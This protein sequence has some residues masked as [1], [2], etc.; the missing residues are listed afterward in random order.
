MSN[1]ELK[2][3]K[4]NLFKMLE[5]CMN[6][7]DILHN[8]LDV[9]KQ[10]NQN[11]KKNVIDIAKENEKIKSEI[12][13]LKDYQLNHL[14]PGFED[15][16]DY[17]DMKNK[18]ENNKLENNK[19]KEELKTYKDLINFNNNNNKKYLEEI[20]Y[21]YYNYVNGNV[22]VNDNNN[23]NEEIDRTQYLINNNYDTIYYNKS[24]LIYNYY[25]LYRNYLK[26]KEF[27]IKAFIKNNY[28]YN[29]TFIEKIKISYKF[30]NDIL[31]IV[32]DIPSYL[33]N[34]KINTL[35]DILKKC[36]IT[37]N[38]LYNL[39]NGSY[40]DLIGFITPIII[41][42]CKRKYEIDKMIHNKNM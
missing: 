37:E 17:I 20:K 23:K 41:T 12:I 10:Q 32:K 9:L 38:K 21:N 2:M 39:E 42:E 18:M 15:T 19:L 24:K 11:Y 22:E 30:F 31:L 8:E 40:N 34:S 33:R 1:N 13:I 6:K 25:L 5:E 16:K 35:I 28:K 3:D 36:R 14:C 26:E 4:N 27:D 7:N 29:D